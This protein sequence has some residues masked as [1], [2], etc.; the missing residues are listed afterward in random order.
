MFVFRRHGCFPERAPS[1]YHANQKS[2]GVLV[3]WAAAA[4]CLGDWLVG[5]AVTGEERVG[6]V[7]GGAARLT[8]D[9]HLQ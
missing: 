2:L 4:G 6:L 1:L 8:S 7:D 9:W 5:L 3:F